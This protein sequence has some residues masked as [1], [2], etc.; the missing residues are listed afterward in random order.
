MKSTLTLLLI[1]SIG[2]GLASAADG[3]APTAVGACS[4]MT[5]KEVGSRLEGAPDSGSA[6]SYTD[7]TYQVSYDVIPE[8][9]ATKPGD[10][11]KLCLTSL[12]EDCPKGD[13]RGKF[14]HGTNLRTNGEWELPD[15]EHMCGGA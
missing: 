3:T 10:Q 8:I 4:T 9:Q 15:S 13:D 5:V 6:I 7:G 11:V 1:A 14:Y 2:S 12:P